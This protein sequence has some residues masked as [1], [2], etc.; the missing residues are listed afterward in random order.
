MLIKVLHT[1]L[2]NVVF[3]HKLW[4]IINLVPKTITV[5]FLISMN[6]N[7]HKIITALKIKLT[8]M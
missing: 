2:I 8:L 3:K 4:D 5:L 6:L 7:N 1:V